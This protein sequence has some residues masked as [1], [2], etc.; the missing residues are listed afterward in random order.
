M[1]C[2]TCESPERET[3]EGVGRL[4]LDGDLSWRTAAEKVGYNHHGPLKHHMENHYLD[5]AV[6]AADS[7]YDELLREAEEDIARRLREATNPEVKALLATV[8]HNLKSLK[9]TKPSQQNLIAA[10]KA[11]H[12]I[13][14]MKIQQSL[15]LGFKANFPKKVE[16]SSTPQRELEEAELVEED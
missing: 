16:S 13:Q 1:A 10:L 12:E 4:A 6:A 9:D 3:I 2:K 14:G 7:A 5:E 8:Y 15:L 11:V